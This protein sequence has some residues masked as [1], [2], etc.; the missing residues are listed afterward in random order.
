MT[1]L[2]DPKLFTKVETLAHVVISELK[3][4]GYI[5]PTKVGKN[6]VSFDGY[7]VGKDTDGFYFIKNARTF[8]DIQRINLP[9]TAAVVANNLAL[10]RVLTEKLI[11]ADRMY[12]YKLFDQEIYKRCMK[13]SKGDVDKYCFY[14]TRLEDA[15]KMAEQHKRDIVNS[16]EKLRS[17]R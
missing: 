12:G 14:E 13:R 1:Q 16:F 4:K 3:Q 5:V 10:G 6:I 9:Q 17:L 7:I 15:K 2:S 11:E 8:T